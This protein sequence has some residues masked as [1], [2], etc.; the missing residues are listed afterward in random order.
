M[1]IVMIIV[2]IRIDAMD[3]IHEAHLLSVTHVD[4][5]GVSDFGA[6]GSSDRV[7]QDGGL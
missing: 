6:G 3:L 1:V 7:L 2:F 4:V 5:D